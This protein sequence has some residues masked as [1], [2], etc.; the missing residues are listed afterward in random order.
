MKKTD[1]Y[2]YKE[3]S[4]YFHERLIKVNEEAKYLNVE[5]LN[6]IID[7]IIK[8]ELSVNKNVD[9]GYFD[10]NFE[11]LLF[12]KYSKIKK[13]ISDYVKKAMVEYKIL[14][15]NLAVA[16]LIKKNVVSTCLTK[17]SYKEIISGK[18]ISEIQKMYFD[19]LNDIRNTVC[20][21]LKIYVKDNISFEVDY[22]NLEEKIVNDVLVLN[23]LSF[24]DMLAM[25][26]KAKSY[27]KMNAYNFSKTKKVNSKVS[28]VDLE[29]MADNSIA[30]NDDNDEIVYSP[31]KKKLSK[32]VVHLLL[33]SL[34][35]TF[36]QFGYQLPDMVHDFGTDIYYSYANN[37]LEDNKYQV[38]YTKYNENFDKNVMSI[39]GD[40]NEYSKYGEEYGYLGFY[41]AYKHVGQ[42]RLAIMD[43]M[44]KMVKVRT[45]N[46]DL[47]NNL[48]QDC[49]VAFAFNRL[50]H[51]DCD[52][53]EKIK[54]QEAVMEYMEVAEMIKNDESYK[55]KTVMDVLA[56]KKDVVKCIYEIM[57]LYD[58]YSARCYKDLAN[59]TT[60]R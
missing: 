60:R 36:I 3:L 5:T 19:Y 59:H 22:H 49:F 57:D 58:D 29:Q 34:M 26:D 16:D 14:D 52:E 21:L 13:E 46:E 8:D 30:K 7:E 54:Y 24:N 42:D 45:A 2:K 17:Y 9:L 43:D 18:V 38:I 33:I 31:V 32:A 27:I 48:K 50:I 12:R 44:L 53:I 51:M 39:I 4:L 10:E 47:K 25:N 15:K 55:N 37:K 56:D 40:Y 41:E 6:D 35:L 1:E 23:N 28:V 20:G 11:A